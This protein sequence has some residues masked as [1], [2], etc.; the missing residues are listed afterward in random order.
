MIKADIP[1]E[2]KNNDTITTTTVYNICCPTGVVGQG[3]QF[4]ITFTMMSLHAI[5]IDFATNA[6]PTN[7]RI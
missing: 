3:H 5:D 4:I 2:I 1:V 7:N 6:M